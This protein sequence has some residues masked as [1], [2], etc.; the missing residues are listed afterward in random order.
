VFSVE[1]ESKLK[2]LAFI[3]LC[4]VIGLPDEKRP[5]N[6][7]VTLQVQLTDAAKVRDR[8]EL[9]QDILAF[10]RASMAPYKVPRSVH[11]HDALPLT[12][13][14]KLDKKA[15]RPAKA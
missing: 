5:G 8:G 14:G 10:C 7:I 15:L 6:D 13:V 1:V 12:A 3:D 2:E 9:E 4:A 11:F